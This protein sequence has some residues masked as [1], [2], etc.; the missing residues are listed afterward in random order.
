MNSEVRK[1]DYQNFWQLLDDLKSQTWL[2]HRQSWTDY[3]FH[4]THVE[5]L[6]EILETGFL[7]SRREVMRR[8]K[9]RVDAASREIL[10]KRKDL[11]DLV[12]LYFRPK[13]PTTYHMEGI[14]SKYFRKYPEAHCSIPV[15]LLFDL[16][17]VLSLNETGFSKGSPA[18]GHRIYM[19][20]DEFATMP[21]KSIYGDRY[22]YI[23]PEDTDVRHAEVVFP[24]K[25]SLRHL[26]RI[27]CRSQAEFDTLR[28]I[29]QE[30]KTWDGWKSI[31]GICTSP[32]LFNRKWLFVDDVKLG[33]TSIRIQFH[34]PEP[35]EHKGPFCI[36]LRVSNPDKTYTLR[37][38]IEADNVI[39]AL[40]GSQY[41]WSLPAKNRLRTDDQ[42]AYDFDVTI[43]DELA[44][45]GSLI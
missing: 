28:H 11:F 36:V 39:N 38:V 24:N 37:R 21:F 45:K 42:F 17:A 18:N 8:G 15:Y 20:S 14:K 41:S 9:L 16:R 1:P 25:L 44:F 19:D 33:Q 12:R 10:S 35:Q 34:L 3:L 22:S 4:L 30:N 40:G 27:L 5:N 2:G 32:T 7:L 29:C 26:K 31:I 13:T 23:A 6:A 43:E